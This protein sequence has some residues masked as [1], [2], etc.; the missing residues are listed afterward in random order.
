MPHH[1]VLFLLLMVLPWVLR[2]AL[3]LLARYGGLPLRPLVPVLAVACSAL[4]IA[5]FV[6]LVLD[7]RY[8][9]TIL[10]TAYSG[11]ILAYSWVKGESLFETHISNAGSRAPASLLRI[12][13]SAYV[14]V[15]DPVSASDWYIQKLG[16]RKMAVS[17]EGT[18]EFRF[19]AEAEPLTLVPYDQFYP[20]PTPMLYT[21]K[22]RRAWEL[23]SSRGVHAGVIE[24]DCQGTHSFEVRDSEGNRLEVSEEP[25]G[26][27]GGE[28]F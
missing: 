12:A 22:I 17:P 18:V 16:L 25:S 7:R 24:Q 14:G 5:A 28:I 20:R 2:G 6:Y 9:Q 11:L 15:R 26:G 19:E 27:F 3:Y 23:L 13:T 4:W 8:L 1:F 10:L 21:R